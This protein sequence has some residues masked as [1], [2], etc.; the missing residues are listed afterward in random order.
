MSSSQPLAPLR[1]ALN[2]LLGTLEA[3]PLDGRLMST[4]SML[5]DFD[6]NSAALTAE[7]DQQI[8]D[9]AQFMLERPEA[10]I[11]SIVGRASQTGPEATNRALA[12]ARAEQVATALAAHGL[13]PSRIGATLSN[14]SRLPLINIP[15]REAG[16]NRSVEL[17]LE[18]RARMASPA[19][20]AAAATS[21]DWVLDLSLSMTLTSG[22]IKLP[23]AGQ[24]Q[25]GELQ[26]LDASGQVLETRS[27]HLFMA[28]MDWGLSF[29]KIEALP[30]FASFSTGAGL[31]GEIYMPDPPGAVDADWFDGRCVMLIGASAGLGVGAEGTALLF[32]SVGEWPGTFYAQVTTGFQAGAS[33]LTG[34]VGVL[35]IGD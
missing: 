10:C 17:T 7:H 4:L 18:W 29:K 11:V 16:L 26:R 19:P 25:L 21:T 28:G 2:R 15:G 5:T 12:Q 27:A 34:L 20:A 33:L 14:G 30:I 35:T 9:I 13:A 1:P 6:V 22:L 23:L 3:R 24:V 8:A 31:G 32:P